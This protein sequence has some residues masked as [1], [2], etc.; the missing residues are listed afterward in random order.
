MSKA[1]NKLVV[2]LTNFLLLFGEN[3]TDNVHDL[4]W[5]QFNIFERIVNLHSYNKVLTQLCCDWF[6]VQC[7][8]ADDNRPTSVTNNDAN[9]IR[10]FLSG[11]VEGKIQYNY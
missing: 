2:I 8:M 11:V 1:E 7:K 3:P 6:S 4:C 9:D 5:V 10:P